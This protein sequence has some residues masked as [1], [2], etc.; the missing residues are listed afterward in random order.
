MAKPSKPDKSNPDAGNGSSERPKCP[1][2]GKPG[3]ATGAQQFRNVR[4]I[5]RL[6]AHLVDSAGHE[7]W[8]RTPAARKLGREEDRRR[9]D[10]GIDGL[11][12]TVTPDDNAPVVG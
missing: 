1:Q 2:C 4:G 10:A 11:E 7:W 8:D 12:P 5:R 3:K 9:R 6:H